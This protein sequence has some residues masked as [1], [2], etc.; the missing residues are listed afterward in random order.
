MAEWVPAGKAS[1][2]SGAFQE[3]INELGGPD[4]HALQAMLEHYGITM[5]DLQEHTEQISD[6]LMELIRSNGGDKVDNW[7][8]VYMVGTMVGLYYQKEN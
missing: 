7:L 3:A 2:L 5:S 6:E 1:T 8:T 4:S